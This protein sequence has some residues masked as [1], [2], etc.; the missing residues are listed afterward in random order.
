MSNFSQVVKDALE[1]YD[2]N[3]IKHYDKIKAFKYYQLV[4]DEGKII[5]Y[6]DLQQKIDDFYYDVIGKFIPKQNVWI[7]GWS[8]GNLD[9]QNTMTSRKVLNYALDLSRKEILLKTA[10]I[11]SRIQVTSQYQVDIHVALASFL[12]KRDFI[13]KLDTYGSF[14]SMNKI[15]QNQEPEHV[16]YLGFLQD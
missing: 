8:D 2:D 11:T 13:Y 7:W 10:L 9:K 14:E 16:Y 15:K 6:D 4:L 1:Y 12:S 5:F 3:T